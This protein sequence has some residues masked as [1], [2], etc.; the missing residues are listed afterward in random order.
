MKRKIIDGP[1]KKIISLLK[2][3]HITG[4]TI[5]DFVNESKMTRSRV[6]TAISRLEG[7]GKI[8]CE[9]VSKAKLY[10]LEGQNE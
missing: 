7:A 8:S 1:E 9:K 4:M 2:K 10:F 3:N 6:K 5:T